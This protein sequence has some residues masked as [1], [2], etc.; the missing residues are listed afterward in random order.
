M[1]KS[2]V[3][4]PERAPGFEERLKALPQSAGVY[5]MRNRQNAI[6]YVGKAKILPNRVRTYFGSLRGQAPKVWRMVAEVYDFEYIVTDTEL[7]A[8]ILESQLVKKHQPRYNIRLK[9]DKSYPY[10]KVTLQDPWPRVVAT[11]KVVNDGAAYYGP[12]AGMGSVNETIDLLDKLFPFRTCDKEITGRDARPCLEYFIHRC[13][14]PCA[15]L[16]DKSAYDAAVKQVMLFLDG[17]QESIVR[18]LRRDMEAAS[19]KLEFERAA[20]VRDRIRSLERVLEQQK[21]FSAATTDEDVIAFA[22]NDAAAC[23][24]VFFIRGGKLLG[25]EN[26]ML[27]G[28]ADATPGEILEGFMAQF[29]DDAAYVPSKLLLQADVNDAEIIQSWLREKRGNKVTISVPR[30]GEKRDLI[31]MASRNAAETLEQYRLRWLSDEQKST[32]ALTELQGLLGLPV[33][34]QRIE[35]YDVAHLQGTDTAGAM[36]VFEQGVPKRK[37][38]RRFQIK[39][40]GNDDY[41]SMHEMLTRRFKRST[42]QRAEAERREAVGAARGGERDRPAPSA[43]YE[44]VARLETEEDSRR[45]EPALGDTEEAVAQKSREAESST[46]SDTGWGEGAWAILPDLIVIDGGKGQLASAKHALLE[47]G[48]RDVP[49]ISLAKKEEHIFVSGKA[50]P[51][52]L[53]KTS[54]ALRLLQRIR[55]EAHRFSN[56]Y[57]RKL[58]AKRAVKSKLDVV[59]LI[60]PVRKKALMRHFGST[61]AIGEA[62]VEDLMAVKGMDRAA[63]L[64]IKEHLA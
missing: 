10:I 60:G 3:P 59:P 40:S 46:G 24:Q 1:S 54:E 39:T 44:A 20:V 57:N 14:G 13:L 22:Q 27:E 29:Y 23:V 6:I 47:S 64:S 9:D 63:A 19:E 41:A 16:A 33:W 21:V 49:L 8:L 25:R 34:P 12:Y 18:S 43:D 62:S 37:E 17:K 4:P 15:G 58:G 5:I 36:V 26:F 55:D 7:E 56:N 11:R 61:K 35:C 48:I 30:R 52:I 53:A 2:M 42:V 28:A 50:E 45:G 38:Y 32:A 51:I 31:E